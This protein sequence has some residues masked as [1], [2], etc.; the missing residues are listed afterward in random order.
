MRNIF[1]IFIADLNGILTHFFVLVV[2]LGLCALPALYAWFN[3]Y[4]NWDPYNNTGN[5]RLAAAI[6]DAGWTDEEG[7]SYNLGEEVRKDLE[8]STAIHWVFVD[9]DEAAEEGVRSGKYYA[10]ISIDE[11][12]SENMFT[13]FNEKKSLP[14]L[15]YY[16][17]G[18]K[19]A[20]ATKVTDTVIG[21][22]QNSINEKYISMTMEQ[23]FGDLQDDVSETESVAKTDLQVFTAKLEHI[24]GNLNSYGTMIGTLQES[25]RKLSAILKT[26]AG[27]LNESTGY[28]DSGSEKLST[29]AEDITGVKSNFNDFST[30]VTAV[31]KDVQAKINKIADG[32]SAEQLEGDAETVKARINETLPLITD[33][34]EKLDVLLEVVM[35]IDLD[36][37]SWEPAAKEIKNLQNI[38]ELLEQNATKT[39]AVT[40][41]GQLADSLSETLRAIGEGIS[42]ASEMFTNNLVPSMNQVIDSMQETLN[43][44]SVVLT[45]LSKTTGSLSETVLQVESTGNMLNDS[46]PE[47]QKTLTGLSDKITDI[48]N[49]INEA[50]DAQ[51]LQAAME[52]FSED[53]S[54]IGNFFAEPVVIEDNFV[55]DIANY[56]SG[57]TPFYTALA[58]WVGMTILVSVLKVHPDKNRFPGAARSELFLG[59]YLVFLL[60]SEIQTAIIVFGELVFFRIQCLHPGRFILTAAVG[61]LTLSLIVY[62]LVVSFGDI[63]KAIAII[64]LVMQIA[65]S[66]GTYPIEILPTFFQNVYL[67]FPFPYMINAM[68]ECIGG[69]YDGT[70]WKCL[71][72]LGV[73]CVCA[74]ILGLLIRLPFIPVNHFVE[75][76]LEETKLI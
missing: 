38:I 17:N 74:L 21:N 6:N 45:N 3:I 13:A 43:S 24:R 50:S 64:M 54:M 53:P 51:K 19:N 47:V 34:K 32:I 69:M 28:F 57:V 18:K 56:G 52:L 4:A 68:R 75:E 71:L 11:D 63:G 33:V 62:A 36:E 59:R 73:F 22:V 29:A 44:L 46:L 10:A 23:V 5:I 9:S 42:Q 66:G 25:N 58:I 72:T 70:Y 55:F 76:R 8:A 12:F 7:G 40:A 27:K 35:A 61:S 48:I 26:S 65:G 16:L 67:L 41:A 15:H 31:L 2:T 1:K 30:N 60:L 49:K 37:V 20:V 39:A 14:Q